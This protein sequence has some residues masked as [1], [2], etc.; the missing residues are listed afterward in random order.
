MTSDVPRARWRLVD[1][2]GGPEALE[3]LVRDLY[4]RLY[5]DL[6]VG[7]LF[8]P[9]D[10]ARLI[11]HQIEYVRAHLGD[12]EGHYTGRSMRRAHEHLPILPGQFDRRHQ[13]LR[14]VLRDHQAP[15]RVQQE[16]IALDLA[17]R[18]FVL[19]M[20]SEAR[21]RMLLAGRDA[22]SGSRDEEE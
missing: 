6:I 17:L 9:H 20:G 16:W 15:A 14:E 13:I 8:A 2:L 4:D 3:A 21:E 12:R 19:R 1:E 10:K 11:A 5:D 7:F 22:S 18:P